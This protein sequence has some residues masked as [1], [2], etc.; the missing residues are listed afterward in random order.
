M[1][2]K[3][4][5]LRSKKSGK[6]KDKKKEETE[7][8]SKTLHTNKKNRKLTYKTLKWSLINK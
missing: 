5:Q 8:E 6:Y 7:K 3:K 2:I 1:L 4:N